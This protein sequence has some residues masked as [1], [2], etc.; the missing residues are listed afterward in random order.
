MMFNTLAGNYASLG[1]VEMQGMR[2]PAFDKKCLINSHSF[3]VFDSD[4]KYDVILGG[5]LMKKVGMN[6]L[7]KTLEV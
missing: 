6:I 4:C 5:D 7:Y 1:D 3:Q 2:L